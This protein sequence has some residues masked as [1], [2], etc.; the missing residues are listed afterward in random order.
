MT[1]LYAC[2]F[3]TV[4]VILSMVTSASAQT[5]SPPPLTLE[6]IFQSP[7]LSGSA[8]RQVKLS[9]AGD[10]VTF[11]Q[12][13]SDDRS[14]MDLWE[15]H[16]NDQVTRRLIAA[17]QVM[18]DEGE[19]S[20]EEQARRE[21]ARISD[22]RGIIDYQFSR[23][24]Q[25]V[26]FPLGGNIFVADLTQAPISVEQIT[27]SED[28]DTDPQLSPDGRY[29]AF[30]RNQN[31]MV[32]A[33]KSKITW[34][35]TQDG[36]GVIKN[37]MAEFIAQEEMG[38]STGFWWSP[39]SDAIA[40]LRVDESPIEV[41]RRYEVNAGEIQMIEQR[42]PFAG[43]DNVTYQLGIVSVSDEPKTQWVDLG[44]ET[45]IYIPRVDWFPD[46]QSLSYQ[47]QS[48]DQKTLSLIRFNR[49]DAK[50]T[51]LLT[52][53]STTW[54]NLHDDLHFLSEGSGL[55]W[56]S[57]RDGFN[58]LYRYDF[59]SQSLTPITQGA[60]AVDALVGV[61]E[62]LGLVYFTA[63]YPDP[64]EKQL[65]R[66][67]LV[68]TA[69]D[70]VE[71]ISRRSGWHD[72]TMDRAAKVYV[73]R[74]SSM[75][76]PPQLSLHR[77]DGQRVAWLVENALNT[78][79]PYAPYLSQHRPGEF[80]TLVG[81]EAQTLHY[82]MITPPN[83]SADNTYP[84]FVH[85]YGGPTSRLA[86]NQW[87]RRALIDQYMAQQGYIVFSLDNRGIV[88]QGKVFQDVA[89]QKLGQI[90]MVDQM[91]GIDWLR[92]QRYVD[93][94]RIGIFGW[95]YGGYMA[96]MAASQYPGEFAASVAVAPVTDWRLYD[97]HYTER[98]MGD[99][100]DDQDVYDRGNVLT[101]AHQIEDP[102]LLIHGMADDN[103]L[104]THSTLLMQQLQD[105]AID[106]DL[107]TY[108]GEKHAISGDGQRLHVYRTITRFLDRH[109]KER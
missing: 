73:D 107:M 98:Y 68:T 32:T 69:P 60:W 101:Y 27:Q 25:F 38:R 59:A 45:D 30:I 67:S 89:Y 47:R 58:H 53:T 85:V 4:T 109:L 93:P 57:E 39:T 70:V 84:V 88:R 44:P 8:L 42:Y 95:S 100:R 3:I 65:L 15:Y 10:R 96:L 52:E 103:V 11:I 91:V 29:V 83:F 62:E 2:L 82:R 104:F 50:Q 24:G 74:Y 86:T 63:A 54:V 72:I 16:I 49:D 66:T 43:T 19:L 76:Q 9:P 40:F 105:Q 80:G 92:S 23:D 21:R 22:L 34:A 90:E 13:R 36:G 97:T 18:T 46:G 48:R 77:A 35:L 5:S 20:Q 17:D 51:I 75:T 87:S 81:P 64:T 6:R 78:E 108:P 94:D 56:S 37:G 33:I 102:L 28:F 61:D 7:E 31:L 55:I 106:F 14:I 41:T 99:P 1:R 26:L 79:H 12:G 71:Q